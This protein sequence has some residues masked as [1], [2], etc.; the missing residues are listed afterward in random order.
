MG[1]CDSPEAFRSLFGSVTVIWGSET[2]SAST[3][4]DSRSSARRSMPITPE[5]RAFEN[6]R[7]AAL[8]RRLGCG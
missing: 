7:E 4:A 8:R 3:A 2:F 6:E 5:I 1:A